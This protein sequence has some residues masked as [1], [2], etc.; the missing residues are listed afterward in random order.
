MSSRRKTRNNAAGA[1]YNEEASSTGNDHLQ[2]MRERSRAVAEREA[3]RLARPTPSSTPFG[4]MMSR[5]SSSVG[6]ASP[7]QVE[8]WCGPFSVARQ[9]IA[10]REEA[11]RLRE[12]Q[13]AEADHNNSK[14]S[15]P[16][17][18]PY[19][20][21][22]EKKRRLENPSMNWVSRRQRTDGGS[23]NANYYAARRQRFIQQNTS[24]GKGV[25]VPSLFTLC[26]NFLVANFESI[27]SLGMI[28]HSIRCALCERL[29]AEGKMTGAAFDVLAEVG[30][31]TMELVDCAQV[32]EDGMA[33]ALKVLLPSGLRAILLN[34]CGRC[35]GSQA[36]K[37][38]T[39]KKRDDLKLFALS[40]GGAYLLKDD[41]IAKLIGAAS[42][43]LSS[44]ELTACPLL[45]NQFTQ[46]LAQHFSSSSDAANGNLLELS[47]QNIPLTKESLL[48]L[49]ASSDALRNLKSLR[50]KE[51]DAVDDE[52]VSV[53]LNSVDRG[54]LEGVDLSNNPQLTDDILS[55]IRR[56]NIGGNL[57]S[58]QL[59]GLKNLTAIGL[60]AFFTPI[61]DMPSP[62]MLRKI[63]LSQCCFDEVNDQVVILAAKASSF[64][65]SVTDAVIYDDNPNPESLV[66]EIGLHG[67]V[68]VNIGGSSVT[69]KS[70]EMLAST[71]SSSLE[72]LDVSFA[73][74]VSD[75]GLGYLVSKIPQ[76][77][78][79]HVW[80]LAQIT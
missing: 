68:H 40:L 2:A 44:I 66:G 73:V 1:R 69:D 5:N 28:D 47:L 67:L 11:R 59:S 22:L 56:C 76:L 65:R 48:S 43:T 71:C 6:K 12:E 35:F 17:D 26:V 9:M 74:N 72:E 8:E 46:S 4:Q 77:K 34:H 20:E 53:I 21:A 36:V 61:D 78:K 25:G 32:T 70:M 42:K 7:A 27:D 19:Q 13:Q 37:V 3:S 14:E 55:S 41:D 31:E 50:L 52:V 51:M 79:L 58:L 33:D 15:N 62:P 18:A 23:K 29:V 10:A 16:L 49:G 64:K 57:R 24:V 39:E 60:E 75:K 45:G 54:T 63:D 30:V 80:G 38:F